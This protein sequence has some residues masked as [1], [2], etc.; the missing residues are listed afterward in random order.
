MTQPLPL[1]TVIPPISPTAWHIRFIADAPPET[2]ALRR[3]ADPVPSVAVAERIDIPL[4]PKPLV[5]HERSDELFVLIVAPGTAAKVTGGDWMARPDHPDAPHAV[6]LPFEKGKISWRPGR[7]LV[8]KASGFTDDALAA[9]AEFAFLEAELRKLEAAIHPM[10]RQAIADAAVAHDVSHA[11]REQSARFVKTIEA[12]S[13]LRLRFARLEPR[14]YVPDRSLP[15][16]PRHLIARLARRAAAEERLEALNDRLE[17]CEDLYEGAVDRMSDFRWYRK[18]NLLEI[19]IVVLLSVE[20]ILLFCD[21]A[22]RLL[23]QHA[24]K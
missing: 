6:S 15:P 3:F 23:M 1:R 24:G 22:I 19:A 20:V 21:V 17:A 18:G 11:E 7:V 10:E 13:L 12:L 2:A 8:E 16:G 9:I 4:L 14:F 5:W